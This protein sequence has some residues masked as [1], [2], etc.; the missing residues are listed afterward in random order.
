MQRVIWAIILQLKNFYNNDKFHFK[1]DGKNEKKISE[2]I[3]D[4]LETCLWIEMDA[5][6]DN[7]FRNPQSVKLK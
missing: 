1:Y 4:H 5:T 6:T 2:L 7:I 3:D